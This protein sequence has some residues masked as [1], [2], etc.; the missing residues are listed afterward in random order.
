MKE[1]KLLHEFYAV[2]QTSVYWVTDKRDKNS[3]PLVKK[4]ALKGGSK[5][6]N[7][8]AL[9]EGRLVGITRFG[10]VL[11]DDAKGR[12]PELI[13]IALW[14]GRSSPITALFLDRKQA[15]ACLNSKDLQMC[16][17]RWQQQTKEVVEAIDKN[18]PIF[19]VSGLA[20]P[21]V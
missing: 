10:I 16:D 5:V 9:K 17:C 8:G 14:G 21:L 20:S 4:I 6:P 15:L 18:H 13:N 7:G 11:Y 19:V 2:T 3:V 1:R 12:D